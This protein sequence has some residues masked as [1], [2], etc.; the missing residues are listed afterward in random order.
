MTILSTLCRA[1]LPANALRLTKI[2]NF[3]TSKQQNAIRQAFRTMSDDA[4]D[5]VMNITPSRHQ[6]TRFKDDLHFYISLGVIP[7]GLLI[8][9]VNIFIG[10][11][12]LT[13]IPEDYKPEY[14]E[15]FQHP[16]KRFIAKHFMED[17]QVIYERTLH[18]LKYDQERMRWK[19]KI[20]KVNQLMSERDDYKAWFFIPTDQGRHFRRAR[21]QQDELE[22]SKGYI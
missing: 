4:G 5:R 18:F 12:T 13:E 8:L 6:Y 19:E 11:A 22:R 2:S 15:Y 9:Y 17:P 21:Q 14:H 1:C 3:L 10:P 16:I 7:L 20:D